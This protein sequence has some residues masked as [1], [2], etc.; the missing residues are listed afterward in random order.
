RLISR[1]RSTLGAE[2]GVRTLFATP[3]PAGLSAELRTGDVRTRPALAPAAQRPA[4]IPL[5]YAQQRLWF[6]R[7]WDESGV[8]YNVPL[9][10]RLRGPLDAVAIEAALNDVVLRHEALRTLFP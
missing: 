9:A 7:E 6:L 1:I 8:T 5:S 2:V 3:T 10:V 4:Q